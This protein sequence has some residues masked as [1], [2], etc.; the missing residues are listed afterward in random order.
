MNAIHRL[1]GMGGDNLV[2]E[3]LGHGCPKR[4]GL[5]QATIN[6]SSVK[7]VRF[8]VPELVGSVHARG[9]VAALQ[10]HLRLRNWR[11]C[12]RFCRSGVPGGQDHGG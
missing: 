1:V 3:L 8:P 7:C 11:P 6:N 12:S 2:T 5:G 9:L 4:S 10:P